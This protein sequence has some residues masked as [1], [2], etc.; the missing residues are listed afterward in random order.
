[1]L[2][3]REPFPVRVEAEQASGHAGS[4]DSP[5]KN[6]ILSRGVRTRT[7]QCDVTTSRTRRWFVAFI[8]R[9]ADRC[10]DS[11]VAPRK[12][13]HASAA[14]GR[15]RPNRADIRRVV[16]SSLR[17]PRRARR[18]PLPFATAKPLGTGANERVRRSVLAWPRAMRTTPR[19]AGGPVPDA[20]GRPT[21]RGM[22]VTR[23]VT[24]GSPRSGYPAASPRPRSR[25]RTRSGRSHKMRRSHGLY[26]PN[27]ARMRLSSPSSPSTQLA[28]QCS[29]NRVT[30]AS[31]TF[32][33]RS[34]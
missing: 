12:A 1:M 30:S 26:P 6:T 34:G 24:A 33:T 4:V 28:W 27:A 3:G 20:R 32:C 15:P 29:T 14:N 10:K 18:G 8:G 19:N 16:R 22:C 31:S 17:R 25:R 13:T 9:K 11:G 23:G 7:A 21:R 5:P 2:I